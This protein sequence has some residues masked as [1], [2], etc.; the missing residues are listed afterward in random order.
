MSERTE[1]K[2][3]QPP[4]W[5]PARGACPA[6]LRLGLGDLPDEWPE[7]TWRDQMGHTLWHYW[8]CCPDPAARW[9]ALHEH[10]GAQ[11]RDALGEEGA[12][13]CHWLALQGH[14]VALALWK[15]AWGLPELSAWR[16]DSLLHCAAWSGDLATLQL[17]LPNSDEMANAL[18]TQGCPS[19]VMAVY[20]GGVEHVLALIHAGADPNLRDA[21]GRTALHHAALLGDVDLMGKM[22]DLGGDVRLADREGDTPESLLDDRLEMPPAQMS[23]LRQHWAR[24][25]QMK[26]K[27]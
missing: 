17:C 1:F 25:Y 22:E 20:R 5:W 6:A 2:W 8:A 3:H 10:A 9:E 24:R 4:G 15:Q 16:G 21:Y 27:F 11:V 26:L 7:A 13:P 14:H 12:H 19:L 23:A 18:D